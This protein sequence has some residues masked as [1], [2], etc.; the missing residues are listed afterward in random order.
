MQLANQAGQLALALAAPP[1]SLPN[2]H[3]KTRWR[4]QKCKLKASKRSSTNQWVTSLFIQSMSIDSKA[5]DKG[6]RWK[7]V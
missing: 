1:S 3:Q 4:R 7:Y 6:E 5:K 2:M